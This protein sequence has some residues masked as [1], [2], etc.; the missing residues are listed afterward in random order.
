MINLIDLDK[1]PLT[2]PNVFLDR[3]YHKIMKFMLRKSLTKNIPNEEN[4]KVVFFLV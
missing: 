1:K 2:K 3:T 4:C